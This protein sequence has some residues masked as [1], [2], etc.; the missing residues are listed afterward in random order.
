MVRWLFIVIST[1]KADLDLADDMDHLKLHCD[2]LALDYS[3]HEYA[4]ALDILLE[5]AVYL[6]DQGVAIQEYT[7]K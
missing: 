6:C 5:L 4:S 3:H 7:Y 1:G 2:F